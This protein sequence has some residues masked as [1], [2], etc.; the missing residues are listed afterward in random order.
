[1]TVEIKRDLDFLTGQVDGLFALVTA[2]A[3]ET[4]SRDAFRTAAIASLE[5]H[6]NV[7]LNSANSDRRLE[8]LESVDSWVQKLTQP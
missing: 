3:S 4:L 7:L 6:R 1:M 2:I 8:G 5:R